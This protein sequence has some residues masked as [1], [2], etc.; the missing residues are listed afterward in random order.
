[1]GE[2]VEIALARHHRLAREV[3]E[4]SALAKADGGDRKRRAAKLVA[5]VGPRPIERPAL[6]G[7][8]RGRVL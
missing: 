5:E 7:D 4:S 3:D 6:E 8:R 1:M 2:H